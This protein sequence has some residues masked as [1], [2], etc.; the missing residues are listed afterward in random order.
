MKK[1]DFKKTIPMLLLAI[2]TLLGIG[3]S[4]TKKPATKVNAVSDNEAAWR[5]E[6]SASWKSAPSKDVVDS[7][8]L[9]FIK[10]E[11]K[12]QNIK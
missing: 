3:F 10:S 2:S 4:I 8:F 1:L 12:N 6:A 7:Y 11:L 9:S 5:I